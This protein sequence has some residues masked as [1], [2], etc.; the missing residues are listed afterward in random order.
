MK[1]KFLFWCFAALLPFALAG[2]QPG[3]GRDEKDPF[4][5]KVEKEKEAGKS[6]R[7]KTAVRESKPAPREVQ[8]ARR[9]IREERSAPEGQGGAGLREPR[10]ENR[11]APNRR[12]ESG[13]QPLRNHRS[14]EPAVREP[15]LMERGRYGV[16]NEKPQ[17]RF[18]RAAAARPA[19]PPVPEHFKN[20]GISTLPKP[21]ANKK[22]ILATPP[23]RSV[24]PSPP[25]GPKGWSRSPQLITPHSGSTRFVQAKMSSI[26]GDPTLSAKI[27][28]Y[29][30]TETRTNNYYWH[31]DGGYNYCHYYDPWG[32]SWYGWYFDSGFF[33][34]RY[35]YDRW[36]WYDDYSRRWC[37]WYNGWWWWQD[38]YH[39]N[40]I[41]VYD[42]S[43][44]LPSETVYTE[45][46]FQSGAGDRYGDITYRS[47]DRTRMVRLVGKN[48]DA[49]LYD[50]ADYPAF[51]PIFLDSGV[52]EVRFSDTGRGAPLQIILTLQDGSFE[53]FDSDGNP[54]GSSPE[55]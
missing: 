41:Y 7:E 42:G 28:F 2:A 8:P 49:I 22:R 17:K 29:N 45:T 37:Y 21:I 33:W 52:E 48:R 18:D 14:L 35:Y 12:D 4:D 40:V 20:L 43:R 10:L 54:F 16:L 46:S 47:K 32:Y 50:T 6:P 23:S 51:R 31:T 39:A 15:A 36:W 5:A 13:D 27:N 55:D 25:R 11:T 9:E 19:H 53:M 1:K 3:H 34:T 24:L 38:P 44:Y 30:T 26:S